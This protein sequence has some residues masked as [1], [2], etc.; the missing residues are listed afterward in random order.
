VALQALEGISGRDHS[1]LAAALSKEPLT[2]QDA[3]E[4]IDNAGGF[5]GALLHWTREAKR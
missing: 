3:V 1:G 2:Y 5:Y 4:I